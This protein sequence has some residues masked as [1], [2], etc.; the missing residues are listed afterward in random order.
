MISLYLAH[1]SIAA[2]LNY[3][4][5]LCRSYR[6]KQPVE[7]TRIGVLPGRQDQSPAALRKP[8]KT[9]DEA[10]ADV[11]DVIHY[12]DSIWIEFGGIYRAGCFNSQGMLIVLP[13]CQRL[14]KEEALAAT[15]CR[16]FNRQHSGLILSSDCE[17]EF[18][19]YRKAVSGDFHGRAVRAFGDI[20][21]GK[22]NVLRPA[23]AH[24]KRLALSW[25]VVELKLDHGFDIVRTKVADAGHGFARILLGVNNRVCC[26][27]R[28]SEIRCLRIRHVDREELYIGSELD[29]RR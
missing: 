10:V 22:L 19:V 8:L 17:E 24:I 9:R 16:G 25:Q 14:L 7:V 21:S 18:V 23:C 1:K 28:N 5:D 12:D 6:A 3:L 27:T 20:E 11:R 15:S 4:P 26:H 13:R 2:R 29:L